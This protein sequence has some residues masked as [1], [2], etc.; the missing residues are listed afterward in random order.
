MPGVSTWQKPFPVPREEVKASLDNLAR[1]KSGLFDSAFWSLIVN[2]EKYVEPGLVL[3]QDTS[4]KKYVPYSAG[5]SYGTGSDTA[6]GV[7][8]QVVPLTLLTEA[9]DA[10][11]EP[12]YHGELVEAFCFVLGSALGTVPAGVKTDLPDIEWK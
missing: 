11:C 5:A 3:A 2:D 9:T 10:A 6:V 1:L 12:I 7:L 4:S 8:D